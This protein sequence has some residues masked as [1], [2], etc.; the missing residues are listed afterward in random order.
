MST[1]TTFTAAVVARALRKI[2][3]ITVNDREIIQRVISK[4]FDEAG[5]IV[6]LGNALATGL[7]AMQPRFDALLAR[8]D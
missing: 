5:A 1:T 3:A 8:G 2:L 6:F 4:G 7:A